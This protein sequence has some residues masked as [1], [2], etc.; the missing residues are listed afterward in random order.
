MERWEFDAFLGYMVEGYQKAK[1]EEIID[2]IENDII[3][4]SYDEDEIA[5]KYGPIIGEDAAR[6]VAREIY[7]QL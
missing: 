2:N 7:G 1:I 3:F 4:S 6:E 5:E